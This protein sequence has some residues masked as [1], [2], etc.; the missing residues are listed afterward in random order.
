VSKV[1]TGS[2][3]A[4]VDRQAVLNDVVAVV[5]RSGDRPILLE[6][7]AIGDC[8]R[9]AGFGYVSRSA[10][11][12]RGEMADPNDR[13][14]RGRPDS[15]VIAWSQALS[16]VVDPK[17]VATQTVKDGCLGVAGRRIFVFEQFPELVDSVRAKARSSKLAPNDLVR[18][19]VAL[20]ADRII[21]WQSNWP[22]LGVTK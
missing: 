12:V 13:F 19:V 10:A 3:A 6:E 5:L 14:W 2:I 18:E 22:I 21:A 8:M 4:P 11:E 20:N 15:E 7:A 9:T 16:G 1:S 17:T